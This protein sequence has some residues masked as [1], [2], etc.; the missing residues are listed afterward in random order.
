MIEELVKCTWESG[1]KPLWI[2]A[3]DKFHRLWAKMNQTLTIRDWGSSITT[4]QTLAFISDRYSGLQRFDLSSPSAHITCQDLVQIAALA[5]LRS[6]AISVHSIC[7]DIGGGDA[8]ADAFAD[9]IL[10]DGSGIASLRHLEINTCEPLPIDLL[11]VFPGGL[12]HLTY[13]D[14]QTSNSTVNA[15]HSG[16]S[17]ALPLL[18]KLQDLRT[19]YCMSP[20]LHIQYETLSGLTQLTKLKLC[21][22]I[23]HDIPLVLPAT[24][25]ALLELE[26]RRC[27]LDL[28]ALCALPQLRAV[29][30]EAL[31]VFCYQGWVQNSV[32]IDEMCAKHSALSEQ[33]NQ[34]M[35]QQLEEQQQIRLEYEVPEAWE[36]GGIKMVMKAQN[37]LQWHGLSASEME[38]QMQALRM[39]E[40]ELRERHRALKE[41]RM[42]VQQ[43]VKER[44]QQEQQRLSVQRQELQQELRRQ[45]AAI[46]QYN[47]EGEQEQLRQAWHWRQWDQDAGGTVLEGSMLQSLEIGSTWAKLH[48]S[49]RY[50]PTLP[51]LKRLVVEER[52]VIGTGN[53]PYVRLDRLLERHADTLEHIELYLQEDQSDPSILQQ[54]LPVVLQYVELPLSLP[55]CKEL[56]IYSTEPLVH[57]RE[58]PSLECLNLYMPPMVEWDEQEVEEDM[59]DLAMWLGVGGLMGD[60]GGG[61]LR[62]LFVFVKQ[63]DIQQ[64]R[65]SSW[66][67]DLCTRL[68]SEC[69]VALAIGVWKPVV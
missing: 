52:A 67:K 41:R 25:T 69:D 3:N 61:R 50:V 63:P 53:H 12:Q 35:Q 59:F 29:A 58:L 56:H 40:K 65:E 15:A 13:L 37:K 14:L 23:V 49:L 9:A 39:Q 66:W 27:L 24:M 18:G 6:L 54:G 4:S 21:S 60:G 30:V 45:Q 36:H 2:S 26:A 31:G 47:L 8:A 5:S 55:A 22:D 46:V 1:K 10:Y 7:Q 33:Y 44:H 19:S 20:D 57:V 64:L 68:K 11:A 38:T 32:E 16:L 34:L 51:R 28:E 43:Q 62:E 48:E 42:A 17:A